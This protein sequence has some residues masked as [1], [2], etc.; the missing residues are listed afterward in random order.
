MK[1]TLLNISFKRFRIIKSQAGFKSPS[2]IT[3][4]RSPLW[5]IVTGLIVTAV[6]FTLSASSKRLNRAVAVRSDSSSKS[7]TVRWSKKS[8]R[9]SLSPLAPTITAT[10][11]DDITLANKKN[12]GDPITYTAVI[13]NSG[14]DAT[15]VVYTDTLDANTTQTG[16]VT[17]SPLA[18]NE[19]YQSIGNMT[20]TSANLGANCGA[21]SLRS[22]TCNDTL[23]GAALVGFGDTQAHANNVAVNGTNTVTTTNGGTV[24]LNTDG[25]FVYDPGA[26]F[27]GADTFWYTLSNTSVTPNLTDNA[28]VTINVGGANGMVWFISSAGGGTG[29]QANPI[30]I[31]A[32][33][34]TNTGTGSNPNDGDTIFLF[35]GAH[36]LTATL[37]LRTNQKF[38]GQDATAS[39]P[40]LGGPALPSNGGSTAG[41]AYPA[42]NPSG[43]AVS[44]TSSAAA[45]TLGSGNNLAGFTV[46]NSTTAITGGAVGTF[47]EREVTINTNGQG[48][49]ISTSGA[50]TTD[51]TFTGFTSVTT[52]GG[53]NGVSLTGLTGTLQLGSGALSGASGAT[54]NVS[55]GT[56][57]ITYSGNISQSNNAA[58]VNISGH[59][60]GTITFQTGTLSA[61]NGTGL[62]FSNADGVYNFNGTNTLNG[63]D[64]GIDIT[65]GSG[66]TFSF[67]SNTTITSPTGVAFNV[68]GSAPV[69]KYDGTITQ[70]NGAAAVSIASITGGST[71]G[72]A[73]PYSILF[74]GNITKSSTAA[75]GISISGNSGG[76]LG[77][78]GATLSLSTSTANTIDITGSTGAGPTVTFA[79]ATSMA[80][81]TTSGT[82][83]NVNNSGGLSGTIVVTGSN[84]TITT[85]TGTGAQVKNMNIGGSGV[86]FKSVTVN[87]AGPA[88]TG[89][90][91]IVDTTGSSGGFSVTGSTGSAIEDGSGGTIANL[92]GSDSTTS[93]TGTGIFLNS[94]KNPSFKHMNLH[95]F[96]NYALFGNSVDV[97]TLQYC[98]ING[99]NGNNN[100]S[101]NTEGSVRFLELT[102]SA[103]IKNSHI[104][105]AK[106]DNV[107]V[108]NALDASTLNRL[109][110]DTVTFGTNDATTGNSTVNVAVGGAGTLNMTVNSCTFSGSR[111]VQMQYTMN[112]GTPHGDVIVTN[113][114]IND[115][116][117]QVAGAAGIFLTTGG[118]GSNPTLTYNIDTNIVSDMIGSGIAIGKGTGTGTVSGTI[119]NNTITGN[120]TS[121]GGNGIQIVHVGGGT[122]TTHI[123][124][125]QIHK[126]GTDGILVQIGD[127]TS[128]SN[129]TLNATVT[130]NTVNQQFG[131]FPNAAFD[132]NA[133]T[134]SSPLDAPTLC[135]SLGGAG[136]LK[137]TFTATTGG[138]FSAYVNE[139]RLRQRFNTTT[140]LPGYGGATTDDAAVATF[141][142]TQNTTT[143]GA[144]SYVVSHG[145]N[146]ATWIGGAAC[147]LLLG[148]GGIHAVFAAPS[149]IAAIFDS[150]LIEST[151]FRPVRKTQTLDS[152][153][154]S[155][156]QPQLD[157]IVNAAIA[158]WSATGLTAAQLSAMQSIR[159]EIADLPGSYLGEADGNIIRV[160]TDAAG[161]GW[162]VDATPFDDVEFANAVSLTRHYTNRFGAPAGRL[163]LLTAVM[164]ELGHRVGLPDTYAL[165]TRDDLMYGYLVKGERRLPRPDEARRSDPAAVSVSHFLSLQTEMFDDSLS[166]AVG[167]AG[168]SSSHAFAI[169]QFFGEVLTGAFESLS[170]IADKP[171][172][173]L[174]GQLVTVNIGPLPAGKS[175]TLVYQATVN[176]P[177]LVRSVSTQGNVTYTGGPGGGINTD[178]PETGTTGDA[179][180][181]NINT[182]ITWTGST[183]A[184]WNTAT[185]WNV[186]GPAVSTYAPGITNPAINDVI[187]PSSGVTNEPNIGTTDIGLF[188][189]N[190]ANGRTLTIT[191]P[192]ILTIGGG[193]A[194]DLTLDGIIS[195]GFLN[196]GTGTHSIN[197]A[198]GTGSITPTNTMTVLSG[199]TA[200]LQNNLQADSVTVNAGG[201]L[202]ISNRQLSLTGSLTN[203]GTLTL[204][205][206]TVAFN[207]SGGSAVAQTLTNPTAFNNL[208]INNTSTGGSVTL[209]S[210]VTVNGVLNVTSDLNTTNAFAVSMPLS[211]TISGSGDV[212]GSLTRT[213]GGVQFPPAT[214]ITFGNPF[215]LLNFTVA[216][217]RPTAITFKL[218]KTT[219]D[220]ASTGQANSGFPNAVQR[221]WLITPTGGSGFSATMQLHYLTSELNGNSEASLGPGPVTPPS[222]RLFKYITSPNT[223]WQQQD[224]PNFA[225]TTIDTSSPGNHFVKLVGVTGFSP[226]TIG[227]VS[228]TAA[229]SNVSGRIVDANGNP[230]EGAGVRMSGTQN[231]LTVTDA[232]G[233]YNFAD[234]ETNGFYTV[235]PTRANFS[236]SPQQ[237]SFSQLGLHTDAAFTAASNGDTQNPLDRSEYFVR[238]QYVDF[239]SREP[240]EAGF[241]FWVNNI[242]SCGADAQCREVK[243]IDTSAAFFLSI[244]FQQTGYLVYRTYE[245]AYGD[246]AN[247]P[248]PMRLGECQ[249]DTRAIGNGVI[250][251]QGDWE[252]TLETNKQAFM[253]AF[254][255]RS[256][257]VAAYPV[258]MTPTEFIDKLFTNAGVVPA[259]SDRMAAVAEF[260]SA[261]TTSDPAA[262]ARALRLVAENS[263]LTQKEF[264][265]AF[266]LMEYFGYL[267]RDANSTPDANFDGYNFWLGKLET[268]KGNYQQAELVKAF[269]SSTEY[270]GRFPR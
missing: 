208:T 42:Q 70:A 161:N 64:A 58:M 15:G 16:G 202:N 224:F 31:D 21:N 130:G 233:N 236:F 238:Q 228:P 41:N 262:R 171:L 266:V 155:L 219:P 92:N 194:S 189:L 77:F 258:T 96:Q 188:S 153:S 183:S 243:R 209:G 119:N 205:G 23:N 128:G 180:V 91:I 150:S 164:H 93:G 90:G 123:T 198:G 160:D 60:T 51:A 1:P 145:T 138:G 5:F 24:K 143:S 10:L 32:F 237:R 117:T 212:V 137:N 214:N 54:F 174:S 184:D 169:S 113:N 141:E 167:S 270:R 34:L 20:L 179:T 235:V 252:Q 132:L 122:E 211:A 59:G 166:L 269:L 22:V 104:S 131:G 85:T 222:L 200:T 61:T 63:G 33:R 267:R 142:A 120:T 124:S 178:D 158:R 199:S 210:N 105:G 47:K 65:T 140:R 264:A 165:L 176:T 52:T 38:I 114:T 259:D 81:T 43:T 255:G 118:A 223:G 265:S 45:I 220:L 12:P 254:V 230:V 121:G 78:T 256:R 159:F 67:S 28:Q 149:L 66:G 201:T 53:I 3:G 2:Q 109:T 172:A 115:S 36:A 257:F 134:T 110:F 156:T 71:G 244:E 18:I 79:P 182:T 251:T 250:V 175:I 240:D 17:I 35:E 232:N 27:E 44:I 146:S 206:S 241:N 107:N 95:D 152:V 127:S 94:T 9:S 186:P 46:G 14:T 55:G 191:S 57:T 7:D 231:R 102:G 100:S 111:S 204:T 99:V 56:A 69:I 40:T 19:S 168:A 162:F 49:I 227:G 86:T 48:L 268:F 261:N 147:P 80:L 234:V 248:V 177:P 215:T 125:N 133:G 37:T 73:S 193:T 151:N 213:N 88:T 139:V 221:T 13:N 30:G 135:L 62:Q 29:R 126:M 129:G 245:S 39:V 170:S 68:S 163:D 76:S 247:T 154:A 253:T 216:G 4:P 6:L 192:R 108:T 103:D 112:A 181:T 83:F 136:S 98:T 196:L 187:I 148:E 239:L 226:W 101:P 203:N 50:A 89:A 242:E 87:S 8:A 157:T 185:N 207:A 25:T 144:S 72:I 246:I 249:P 229:N 82:G 263:A 97:F 260:G 75:T 218:T 26:G 225:N 116:Q 74:S 190:I 84:N 106:V 217:T 173:P 197:N 11:A 195:G